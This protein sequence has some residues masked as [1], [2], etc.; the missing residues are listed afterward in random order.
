MRTRSPGRA[1]LLLA[2]GIALAS[3][4]YVLVRAAGNGPQTGRYRAESRWG[5]GPG[6]FHVVEVDVSRRGRGTYVE[7]RVSMDPPGQTAG[8]E[9]R[10]ERNRSG[11]LEFVCHDGW[12]DVRGSFRASGG[13]AVL[14]IDPLG[15]GGGGMGAFY[16][17]HAVSRVGEAQGAP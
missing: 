6:G 15:K 1:A 14:R 7:Y 13:A 5:E 4:G 12:N 9:A 3:L 17:E 8:C 10:A 11:Q 2:G 16:G